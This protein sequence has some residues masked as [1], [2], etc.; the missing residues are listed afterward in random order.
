MPRDIPCPLVIWRLS[1]GKPGHEKQTQGLARALLK[2]RSGVC[3]TLTAPAPL[4]SLAH[5]LTGRFPPGR[6][7]PA[8]DIILAAGHTTHFALLAAR[9]ARGGEAVLLMRPSLPLFLFDLCLIPEHDSPPRRDNVIPLRGVLND[10]ATIPDK[11]PG[12]GLMLIGGV[13][14]HYR[15]DD[16]AVWRAIETIA[17]SQPGVTWRL[18]TSRRTPE[19]FLKSAPAGLPVNL[20]L[21]PHMQTGPGW[22]ESALTDCAQAWVT[23]DSVSMLYEALTAGAAVGLLRLPALRSSRVRR[24]VESLLAEG[25]ITAYD[26]RRAGD[27][28]TTTGLRFNEA[29][30][31]APLILDKLSAA[32]RD[33]HKG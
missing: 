33:C 14:A 12:Q 24:G 5:W 30:R 32:A 2:N 27:P 25:W 21:I 11:D 10:V 4:P 1:D 17:R 6:S 15:W 31:V 13:S 28:L 7:L 18:T 20:C 19:S 26:D 9:R 29:E 3:H 22:L 16:Q 23:E 8:P